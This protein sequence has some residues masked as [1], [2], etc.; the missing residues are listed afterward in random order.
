MNF[1]VFKKSC[2]TCN[3]EL[4]MGFFRI[5]ENI[6]RCSNCGALLIENPKRNVT[7]MIVFF[8]GIFIASGSKWLNIP[9]FYGILIFVISFF[10]AMLITKMKEVK[11]EL[12]IRNVQTNQISF[13]NQSDWEDILNNSQNHENNFEIIEYLK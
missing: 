7:S 3:S 10:I 11:K 8:C 1:N 13:I 2:P 5:R 6:V 12:V 9:L 4:N